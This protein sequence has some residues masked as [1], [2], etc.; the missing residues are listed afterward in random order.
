MEHMAFGIGRQRQAAR[1]ML[2]DFAASGVDEDL[3]LLKNA[4]QKPPT[5]PPEDEEEIVQTGFIRLPNGRVVER[6]MWQDLA[7]SASSRRRADPIRRV[8][9]GALDYRSGERLSQLSLLRQVATGCPLAIDA[10]PPSC[11]SMALVA[12][13]GGATC[14]A[15]AGMAR[16]TT[17]R[18]TEI[19]K[20]ARRRSSGGDGSGLDWDTW[21]SRWAEQLRG[22]ASFAEHARREAEAKRAGIGR[23]SARNEAEYNDVHR[24]AQRQARPPGSRAGGVSPGRYEFEAREDEEADLDMNRQWQQHQQ[25]QKEREAE[26]QQQQQQKQQRPQQ[27]QQQQQQKQHHQ[28]HQRTTPPRRPEPPPQQGPQPPPP[29]ARPMTPPP[30]GRTFD[31]W[32]AFD[33]AFAAWEARAA[34]EAAVRLKDVPFPPSSDPA[35][36]CEKGLLRG[37]DA[38]ERKKLLRKALL[39][40]HPD[41]WMVVIGK[42]PDAE[43]SALGERLSTITQEIVRQKDL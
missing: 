35:G 38:G 34:N 13:G 1:A 25:K 8:R 15:G 4:W 11:S 5:P 7:S 21:E 16:R 14:A 2:H 10:Y 27:Q 22:L 19:E 36:L 32:D 31:S 42:L 33:T 17:P 6:P 20:A 23:W 24:Q 18:M 39:R 41:K 43:K 3:E 12:F 28:Q 9:G 29:M 26:R 40:W 30:I 37:G